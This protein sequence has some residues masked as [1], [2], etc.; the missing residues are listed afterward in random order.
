MDLIRIGVTGANGQLGMSLQ[1]VCQS[2]DSIQ[3]DFFD[4]SQW[5]ITDRSQ[6]KTYIP[7]YDVIINCAAYTQVDRAEDEKALCYLVNRGG[8]RTMAQVCAEHDVLLVHFSSDYV[9]HNYL[10]RPLKESD[11]LRPKGVYAKSK[12]AGEKEIVRQEGPHLIYRVSWL[13]GPFGQNFP[14]TMLRLSQTRDA[15]KVVSDQIGA[16]TN[17]IDLAHMVLS[18]VKSPEALTYA[19]ANKGIYNFCNDGA[20][21]WDQ[22]ARFVFESA[23]LKHIRVHSIPSK[24]YP[25]KAKRPRNSR[26]NLS[27][28]RTKWHDA[29]PG[30]ESSLLRC[31]RR[32]CAGNSQ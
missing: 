26:L 21:A 18:T 24:S 5:D 13:Y 29:I 8:T 15:F 30:W 3:C 11:P 16:P 12:L 1:E 7:R 23:G 14:K 31:I 4:R 19:R 17:T 22:I 25:T 27:K 6:S 2:Y 10:R 28:W 32:L 20:T 9:Y